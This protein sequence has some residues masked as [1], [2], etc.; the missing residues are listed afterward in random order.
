VNARESGISL[1]LKTAAMGTP[2]DMRLMRLRMSSREPRTALAGFLERLAPMT[3]IDA[4]KLSPVAS[5]QEIYDRERAIVESY[6]VIP[7]VWLPQVYGLS[8]RVRDWK[9]PAAGEN[10]PLAD[11]WLEEAP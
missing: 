1:A 10:W 11:I 6:R 9:A 3:G 8:T 5:P 7:L 4:A 2:T